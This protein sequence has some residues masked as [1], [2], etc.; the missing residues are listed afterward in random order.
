MDHVH[1]YPAEADIKA[2]QA[3]MKTMP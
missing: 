2:M 3:C 1:L